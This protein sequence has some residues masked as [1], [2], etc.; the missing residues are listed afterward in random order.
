[1]AIFIGAAKLWR[2]AFLPNTAQVTGAESCQ[3]LL[4]AGR[5]DVN[6]FFDKRLG[7]LPTPEESP[8]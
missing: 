4:I 3:I 2:V 7:L 1:M 8:V 6:P 5:A